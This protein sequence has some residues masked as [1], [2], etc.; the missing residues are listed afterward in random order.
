MAIVR[1]QYK[2][3]QGNGDNIAVT[4]DSNVA[5]GSLLICCVSSWCASSP[6][7]GLTV[8]DDQANSWSEIY[9]V[10][11]NGNDVGYLAYVLNAAAGSTTVT[12]DGP[13]SNDYFTVVIV[14][15]SGIKT[16]GALDQNN[17]TDTSGSSWDSG[18]ITTTEDD[19]YLIGVFAQDTGDYTLTEDA[20]WTLI[21]E[22]EAASVNMPI[23]VGERIVS[24]TL[25]ESYSGTISTSCEHFAAIASFEAVAAATVTHAV[26][27]TLKETQTATHDASGVLEEAQTASHDASARLRETLTASHVQDAVLE[28]TQTA[29][30]AVSGVLKETLTGTHETAAALEQTLTATQIASAILQVTGT[31]THQASGVLRK[32]ATGTHV[33]SAAL[34]DTTTQTQVAFA[35][36]EKTQT[37]THVTS[38]FLEVA[39]TQQHYTWATLQVTSTQDHVADGRLKKTQEAS[40]DTSGVLKE[41]ATAEHDASAILKAEGTTATQVAWAFLSVPTLAQTH[42]TFASLLQTLTAQHAAWAVV[43]LPV[44]K[45][46]TVWLNGEVTTSVT[47][48]A[49]LAPPR[50]A[51]RRDEP[52]LME[53]E[54]DGATLLAGSIEGVELVGNI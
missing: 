23:S 36:L 38:A 53:A 4:F 1:K 27:A 15:V 47:L 35:A 37:Q 18:N 41:A 29:D 20:A 32:A 25:T 48:V 8:S 21:F 10:N 46:P 28:K 9:D 17:N 19:E 13:S 44:I 6:G 2:A 34:Q 45:T 54:Q 26:S 12:V 40:C 33:V 43:G 42:A 11:Y 49:V 14:E 16:S 50:L 39:G 31:A 5:A 52:A 7:T 22:E 51:A 30:F 24:S 3:G